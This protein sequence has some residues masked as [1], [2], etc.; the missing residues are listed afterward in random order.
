MNIYI[1][2]KLTDK[3]FFDMQR[4]KTKRNVRRAKLFEAEMRTSVFD[5]KIVKGKRRKKLSI[6]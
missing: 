4:M 2:L 1:Y 6:N 5:H 3:G